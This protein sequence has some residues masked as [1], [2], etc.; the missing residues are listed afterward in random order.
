MG[1]EA[2]QGRVGM[3]QVAGWLR[4][5]RVVPGRGSGAVSGRLTALAVSAA[6]LAMLAAPPSAETLRRPGTISITDLLVAH[7]HVD[8]GRPGA[9]PGDLDIYTVRLF[10]RRITARPIGHGA[11]TCT[12]IDTVRQDCR[13]TYSL[14]KGAIVTEGVVSSRLIYKLAVIG[15][16]DLYS[17]VRG[18]LTVTSL[19]QKPSKELLVFRLQV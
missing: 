19:R 12:A 17:N 8:L 16:T 18:T 9:S 10:N 14:P 6:L 2:A 15:G 11:M 3:G 4:G 5:R 1:A 7:S 13:A